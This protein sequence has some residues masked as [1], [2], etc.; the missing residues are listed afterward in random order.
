MTEELPPGTP[1]SAMWNAE[2]F[3]SRQEQ[4]RRSYL[5]AATSAIYDR[6][7]IQPYHYD[8]LVVARNFRDSNMDDVA[9]IMA[10]TACEV[11]TE[12]FISQLLKHHKLPAVFEPWVKQGIRRA[13][14]ADGHVLSLYRD[15]SGDDSITTEAFWEPYKRHVKARNGV[16]H[17]GV[18]V[19]K[20][21]ATESCD[22]ALKLIRHFETVFA[23]VNAT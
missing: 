11:A 16:V 9:V 22:I 1:S 20:Q 15:L 23:R 14:I 7:V 2:A 6:G 3:R 21:Q 13:D 12:Y 19:S 10:Q 17:Q 5:R 18:H 8:V 4:Q